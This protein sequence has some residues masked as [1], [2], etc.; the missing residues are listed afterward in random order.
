M[1]ASA[2]KATTGA[3]SSPLNAQFPLISWAPSAGT[4]Q[5]RCWGVAGALHFSW[6]SH[7]VALSSA[8]GPERSEPSM[9]ALMRRDQP[10][11]QAAGY[12]VVEG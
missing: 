4:C 10:R 11:V 2:R 3:Y 6:A 5:D 1:G 9:P 7:A 12:S 8:A